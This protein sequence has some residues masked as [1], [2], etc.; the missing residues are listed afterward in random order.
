MLETAS[1]ASGATVAVFAVVIIFV[2]FLLRRHQRQKTERLISEINSLN[3]GTT[4]E[5]NGNRIITTATTGQT[6]TQQ[7]YDQVDGTAGI[8]RSVSCYQSTS[9]RRPFGPHHYHTIAMSDSLKS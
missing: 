1:I 8:V 6:I 2:Y 9:E 3:N 4:N 7:E 5:E